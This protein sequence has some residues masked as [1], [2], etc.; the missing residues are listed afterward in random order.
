MTE[1]TRIDR[2]RVLRA[3]AWSAPVISIAAAAPTL[4]ASSTTRNVTGTLTWGVK[5]S[6]RR[7]ITSPM[8]KGEVTM[9]DGVTQPGGTGPFVWP[10]GEGTVDEDGTVFVQYGG[11]VNFN[12]HDG[13]LDVT[14]SNPRIMLNPGGTGTLSVTYTSTDGETSTLVLADLTGGNVVDSDTTIVVDNGAVD[15]DADSTNT[16]LAESGVVVF[17]GS[18]TPGGPIMEFYAAGDQMN[19]FETTLTVS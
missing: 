8:A 9:S 4:A 2:R 12:G 17:S 18:M 7:Y 14:V 16:A 5:A 3:G 13:A 19:S 11:T 1:A 10:G 15:P 6:F